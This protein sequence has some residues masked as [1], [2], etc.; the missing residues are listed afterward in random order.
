MFDIGNVVVVWD[1]RNVYR[2]MTDDED[3][4]E[5]F[6]EQVCNS[7]WNHRGDLGEPWHDLVDELAAAHPERREWIEAY[8]RRWGEMLGDVI[9]ESAGALHALRA[10]GVPVYG[11]SNFSAETWPLARDRY[12]VLGAFDDVVVSGEVG[13]AKPDPAMFELAAKRFD[14]TPATTLFIDDRADNIA[15]AESCG[16]QTH[17]FTDATALQPALARMGLLALRVSSRHGRR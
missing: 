8:H 10:A 13:V 4:V 16:W 14:V 2:K 3:A 7:D 17:H 9:Q 6:L 5:A 15:A 11:L 12:D 1:P